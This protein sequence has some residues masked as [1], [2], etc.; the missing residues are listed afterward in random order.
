MFWTRAA[1]RPL[2][3][4]PEVDDNGEHHFIGPKS[5]IGPKF[6]RDFEMSRMKAEALRE[7]AANTDK[8]T[9]VNGI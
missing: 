1:E 3:I 9:S 2:N 4:A 5:P 6:L 8:N 7:N